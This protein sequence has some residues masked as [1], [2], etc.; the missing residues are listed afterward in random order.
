MGKALILVGDAEQADEALRIAVAQFEELLRGNPENKRARM[1]LGQAQLAL[2]D[3]LAQ[4]GQ[5]QLIGKQFEIGLEQLKQVID[6]DANNASY[7]EV[8]NNAKKAYRAFLDSD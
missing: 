7:Q 2:V 3:V 6:S 5:V 8:Y 1:E 4:K